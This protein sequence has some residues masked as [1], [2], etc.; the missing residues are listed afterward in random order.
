[1]TGRLAN[2]VFVHFSVT[3]VNTMTQNNMGKKGFP[4]MSWKHHE[5]DWGDIRAG[6]DTD[7][8]GMLLTG[9]LSVAYLICFL[10]QP[11]AGEWNELQWAGPS[12]INQSINQSRKCPR[13][14]P[15]IQF[16]EANPQLRFL[17]SGWIKIMSSCQK[18]SGTIVK[19]SSNHQSDSIRS[20]RFNTL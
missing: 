2:S 8:R 6:T 10:R 11:P 7:H 14:T 4:Y 18:L 1:M 15:T 5:R 3:V 13:D 20:K 9:F 12:H 16:G 19:Y 17:L